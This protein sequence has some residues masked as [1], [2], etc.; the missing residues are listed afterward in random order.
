MNYTF[1]YVIPSRIIHPFV[2]PLPYWK[3]TWEEKPNIN[4]LPQRSR[5]QDRI[6]CVR[7]S[8]VK[9]PEENKGRESERQGCDIGLAPIEERDQE[10]VLN[11]LKI[12]D[13]LVSSTGTGGKVACLT[14]GSIFPWLPSSVVGPWEVWLTCEQGGEH[15]AKSLGCGSIFSKPGELSGLFSWSPRVGA[16]S[17]QT[18]HFSVLTTRERLILSP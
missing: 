16:N 17:S 6:K 12:S 11:M 10:G 18:S 13:V 4:S 8:L 9:K 2:N 1:G 5:C 3:T 15:K 14:S 7:Y